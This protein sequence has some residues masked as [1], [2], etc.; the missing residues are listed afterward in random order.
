MWCENCLFTS[1]CWVNSFSLL[2]LLLAKYQVQ[3]R[4]IFVNIWIMWHL[5][6]WFLEVYCCSHL[7][8]WIGFWSIRFCLSSVLLIFL[9]LDYMVSE[10]LSGSLCLKMF[11]AYQ[12]IILKEKRTLEKEWKVVSLVQ[13]LGVPCFLTIFALSELAANSACFSKN[14]LLFLNWLLFWFFYPMIVQ[15][16]VRITQLCLIPLIVSCSYEQSIGR[17][18]MSCART[19]TFFFN[20]LKF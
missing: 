5:Y 4:S 8:R 14:Q 19:F 18:V 16:S 17:L 20:K 6:F 7:A 13:L 1:V 9:P 3:V 2:E 12:I 10:L 15:L 11:L